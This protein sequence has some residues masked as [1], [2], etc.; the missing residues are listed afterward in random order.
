[1]LW[2]LNIFYILNLSQLIDNKCKKYCNFDLHN[3]TFESEA[4]LHI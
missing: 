3:L 2:D 4:H 1:M